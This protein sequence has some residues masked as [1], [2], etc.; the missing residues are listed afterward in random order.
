MLRQGNEWKFSHIVESPHVAIVPLDNQVGGAGNFAGH[1][2][3]CFLELASM[4]N[5]L[6]KKF[7][8]L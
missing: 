8:W 6:H 5:C 1:K 2:I 4:A 7:L 3:A